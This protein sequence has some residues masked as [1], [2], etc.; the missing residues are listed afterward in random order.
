MLSKLHEQRSTCSADIWLSTTGCAAAVVLVASDGAAAVAAAAAVA[1]AVVAGV[2]T[3][4]LDAGAADAAGAAVDGSW[5]ACCVTD[6]HHGEGGTGGP[7]A[8]ILGLG[9]ML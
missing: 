8:Q 5:K 9:P 2:A 1:G 4:A 7:N 6:L 3:V